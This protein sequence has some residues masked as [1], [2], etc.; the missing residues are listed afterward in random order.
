M[1]WT[2]HMVTGMVVA[3]FAGQPPAGVI[4]SGVA[5]LLPD[6]DSQNS[7]LGRMLPILSIP[8]NLVFG[9]RGMFHS[10]LAALIISFLSLKFL[11]AYIAISIIIGYL[12][13]LFMD[14]LTP[15]KIPLLWPYAKRFGL[16]LVQTDSF[17]D[18]FLS[19]ILALI[20]TAYWIVP[21]I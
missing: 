2:T 20:L 7:K 11:P 8:I 17:V 12:S 3:V 1:R 6:I 15:S 9:H 13:H 21:M 10:L 5:S 16:P 18:V 4:I 14:A 19:I